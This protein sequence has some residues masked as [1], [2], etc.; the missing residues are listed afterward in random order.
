[1]T[2]NIRKNLITPPQGFSPVPF[3][4]WNDELKKDEIVKQIND[5]Y[6]KEI[7]GFVIHPLVFLKIMGH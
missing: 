4:F 7:D 6:S 2:E 3:W 5:M 1:M